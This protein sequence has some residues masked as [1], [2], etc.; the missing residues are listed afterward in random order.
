MKD[1]IT[2]KIERFTGIEELLPEVVYL[3]F[4][5]AY[6]HPYRKYHQNAWSAAI[7]GEIVLVDENLETLWENLREIV[8]DQLAPE[9]AENGNGCLPEEFDETEDATGTRPEGGQED[10]SSEDAEEE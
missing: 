6:Q 2:I 9:E 4:E 10:S 1:Q 7:D 8:I 3:P 5:N